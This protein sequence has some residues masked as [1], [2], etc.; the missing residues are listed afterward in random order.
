VTSCVLEM[1]K[2]TLQCTRSERV[3]LYLFEHYITANTRELARDQEYMLSGFKL[4]C[5]VPPVFIDWAESKTSYPIF[6]LLDKFAFV[7]I[8]KFTELYFLTVRNC[9]NSLQSSYVKANSQ[10]LAPFPFI[11]HI[12]SPGEPMR[13]FHQNNNLYM[14]SFHCLLHYILSRSA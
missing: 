2:A 8:I 11:I 10:Q 5:P 6:K 4:A 9:Y 13:P 7:S 14:V 3:N 1:G 12:A